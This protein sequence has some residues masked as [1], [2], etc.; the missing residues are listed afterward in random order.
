MK[1]VVFGSAH[2]VGLLQGDRILDLDRA[3]AARGGDRQAFASLQHL[4]ES[5]ERGLD[6]VRKLDESL[7]GADQPEL[8]ADL[9]TVPLQ[10]PFPG[11]RFAFAGSNNADHVASA[12]TNRGQDITA[13]QV[14][15]DI[16]RGK[17]GGFWVVS[18]PVGPDADIPI[19]SSADGL[20]D[21]E[22]EV[23]IVLGK[24]G[25]RISSEDW[26]DHVWGTV[27][28]IDW[29]LRAD[30]LAATH[31]PF[32]AHKTFDASKSL[33]PWIAVDEVEP[34]AC[35]V[36]TYVNGDLRQD[37]NTS[38]M[39]HTYA[40]LL[41]QMSQDLTLLPGDLLAGGTGPGTAIDATVVDGPG[42]ISRDLFLKPGDVVSVTA[43]HLGT[44]TANIVSS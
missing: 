25:K 42:R 10:A 33:G 34:T 31:Q 22:A 29:S 5:G 9:S 27:L 36:Q 44:L 24:G 20:F 21:Y 38:G 3:A 15:E 35:E 2:R 12:R 30:D 11:Q 26:L 4:I 40:E 6:T 1:F 32:Y 19:P 8:F 18:S 23:A 37:F 7:T 28:V 14:R 43:T 16:R 41:E 39:I 17:A 13:E